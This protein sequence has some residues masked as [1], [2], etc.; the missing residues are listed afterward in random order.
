MGNIV[1]ITPKIENDPVSF[2]KGGILGIRRNYADAIR[3]A[4]LNPLVAA[5]GDPEVYADLADGVVFSGGRDFN[6]ARYGEVSRLEHGFDEEL[7]DMEMAVFEA[8]MKRKKPILGICRGIQLINVAL[9]GTLYQDIEA[10]T[11]V[12]HLPEDVAEHTVI[13]E[14]GSAICQ[15][16]G[17]EFLTNSYHHQAVKDLGDGL[18]ATGRSKADGIIEVVEHKTL[19]I[20]GIQWHPERM[21]GA[22][23]T[24]LADMRPL[25]NDFARQVMQKG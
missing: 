16:F 25:F 8:F 15:L 11:G 2:G 1:L 4:G 12:R 24:H 22:E 6:P 9:G 18:L 14:S 23:A 7:D 20:M 3:Q 10:D 13:A 5:Y 19:P 17:S 21:I